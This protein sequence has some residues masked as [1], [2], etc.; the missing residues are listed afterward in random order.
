MADEQ[1]RSVNVHECALIDETLWIRHQRVKC[2]DAIAAG[3]LQKSQDVCTKAGKENP[4]LLDL[5]IQTLTI[6]EIWYNASYFGCPFL[7]QRVYSNN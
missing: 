4:L 2:N 1:I 7:F 3:I 6:G 5:G